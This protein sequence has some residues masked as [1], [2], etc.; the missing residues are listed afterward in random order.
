MVTWNKDDLI[1]Y[2]IGCWAVLVHNMGDNIDHIPRY[3]ERG[4]SKFTG[5]L[6]N[7]LSLIGSCSES[8]MKSAVYYLF[9]D[10]IRQECDADR[11]LQEM[12]EHGRVDAFKRNLNSAFKK[13]WKNL[14]G[15]K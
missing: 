14:K 9:S 2:A 7:Y 5:S 15:D 12:A 6:S 4:R 1:E 10:A 8:Q 3:F 13:S 11:I